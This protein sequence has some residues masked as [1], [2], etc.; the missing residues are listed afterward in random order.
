[1]CCCNDN[2][3]VSCFQIT[4]AVLEHLLMAASYLQIES[5]ISACAQVDRDVPYSVVVYCTALVTWP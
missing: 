5:I 2:I 4:Q 3:H 1:M